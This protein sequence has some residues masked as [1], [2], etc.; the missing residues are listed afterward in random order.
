MARNQT[1][2]SDLERGVVQVIWQR[3]PSSAEEVRKALR[4]RLSDSTVR[5]LL[6]RAEEKGY[7][8]HSVEGKTFIYQEAFAPEEV[9]AE[10]VRRVAD[11]FFGGSVTAL[12]NSIVDAEVISKR[13]LQDLARRI[14]AAEKN[15][16][17]KK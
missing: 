15:N 5:T 13:E 9:G 4:R 12:L 3:G 11:Q 16:R 6:R 8:T 17:G 2:L 14:S 1:E 10:S 7:L